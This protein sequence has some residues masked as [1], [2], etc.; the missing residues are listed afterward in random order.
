MNKLYFAYGSNC[1]NEEMQAR[2]PNATAIGIAVI[3]DYQLKTYMHSTVE[4]TKGKTTQGVVWLITDEDEFQLD[5]YEGYP[6]YYNK[7]TVNTEYGEALMYIMADDHC[8]GEPSDSYS[9]RVLS[10][11]KAWNIP[12]EQYIAS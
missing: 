9:K 11:Y 1:A 7:T 2:C 4:P 8:Y 10:A 3:E 12:A 5:L 6:R